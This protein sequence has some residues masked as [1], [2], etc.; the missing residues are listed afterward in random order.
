MN[1]NNDRGSTVAVS[2]NNLGALTSRWFPTAV[3]GVVA[4]FV[5]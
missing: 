3:G 4:M 2:N 1:P 5:R